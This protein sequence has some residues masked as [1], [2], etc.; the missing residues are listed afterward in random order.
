MFRRGFTFIELVIVITIMLTVTSISVNAGVRGQLA[1]EFFGDFQS[2]IVVIQGARGQALGE[3]N[4]RFSGHGVEF[5]FSSGQRTLR[6]FADVDGNHKYNE[7]NSELI[8]EIDLNKT[9]LYWR[10]RMFYEKKL[11]GVIGDEITDFTIF[12]PKNSFEC[13][14]SVNDRSRIKK[15]IFT[16][17]AFGNSNEPDFD[18]MLVENPTQV[19][20]LHTL[21]CIPEVSSEPLIK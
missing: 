19:L 14:I 13:E 20:S 11:R 6:H 17:V 12:F 3:T 5:K 7:P 15:A 4:D 9:D 8:T 16:E 10:S 2:A 1:A 18:S 21:S